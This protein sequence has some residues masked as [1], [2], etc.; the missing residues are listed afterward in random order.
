MST[1]AVYPGSFDPITKGHVD[2]IERAATIFSEVTI[3]VSVSSQKH[4]T[5]TTQERITL[6]KESLSHLK[7]IKVESFDGLTT[8]YMKQSNIQVLVRGLRQ[9]EDFEY[10]RSM[11]QYNATLHPNVET[12][13]LYSNPGLAFVSSRGV[14]EVARHNPPEDELAKFVPKPVVKALLAKMK[15]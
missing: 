1:K 15:G 10:E 12:M 2:L 5:F 14:K 4:S 9:V 3:L 6:I 11:A 8:D 7:N 13:L